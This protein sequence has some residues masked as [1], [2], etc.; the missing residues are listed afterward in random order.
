ME[1]DHDPR[2][3]WALWRFS[4]LGPLVSA[5]LE[6][7]DRRALFREAAARTRLDPDGRSVRLSPRTIEGWYYAWKKGR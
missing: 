4:I 5:R 2:T 3:R 1:P 6:H 7:G